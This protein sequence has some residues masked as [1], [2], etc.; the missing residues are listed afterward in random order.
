V[1][2]SPGC[3]EGKSKITMWKII[4]RGIQCHTNESRGEVRSAN[5]G[6]EQST[7]NGKRGKYKKTC[8]GERSHVSGVCVERQ[9]K[10]AAENQGT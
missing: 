5:E 10:K 1:D 8:K 6:K 3:D 2:V 9:K 7:K 4:S